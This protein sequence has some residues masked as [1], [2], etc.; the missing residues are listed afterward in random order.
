MKNIIKY[1]GFGIGVFIAL[2]ILDCIKESSPNWGSNAVQTLL[3]VAIYIIF[4]FIT[5]RKNK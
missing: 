2:V 1:A 4:Q 3:T 5:K